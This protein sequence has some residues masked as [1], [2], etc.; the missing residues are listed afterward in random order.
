[1][2]RFQAKG[3]VVLGGSAPPRP[4]TTFDENVDFLRFPL[5]FS[6]IPRRGIA[7]PIDVPVRGAGAAEGVGML[8]CGGFP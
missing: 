6:S 4:K 5:T 7:Y 8:R 2:L 3:G 1:M